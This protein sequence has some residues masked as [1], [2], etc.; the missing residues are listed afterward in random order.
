MNILIIQKPKTI[1]SPTYFPLK[2]SRTLSNIVNNMF[3]TL[4][5]AENEHSYVPHCKRN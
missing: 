1:R 5:I 4:G 2:I 3:L